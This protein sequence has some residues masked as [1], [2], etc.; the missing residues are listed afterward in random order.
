VRSDA[1]RALVELKSSDDF[2]SV[3]LRVASKQKPFRWD[4]WEF[5]YDLLVHP[6]KIHQLNESNLLKL[7]FLI[8]QLK[9]HETIT[10]QTAVDS[11]AVQ[12]IL[13][14]ARRL[15][16]VQSV[17]FN[18]QVDGDY[19]FR[20]DT[21]PNRDPDSYSETLRQYH[22]LL[23]S[24]SLPDGS[25]LKLS[26]Q[27]SGT[28]LY[29]SSPKGEFNLTSD[30]ISH[31]YHYVKRMQHILDAL[32]PAWSRFIYD[33]LHRIGGYSLFPGNKKDGSMTINQARGCNQRIVDRFDLTL[34]CIRRFYEGN[35]SPLTKTF[36]VY[37]DFFELFSS[38]EGFVDFFALQDLVDSKYSTVKF[39]LP[40][41]ETFPLK[42]FPKD[43]DEYDVFIRNTLGF[44]LSRTKRL[45][46]YSQEF[47]ESKP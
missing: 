5:G 16:D 39:F 4:T 14:S 6:K 34:E 1:L 32:D 38:F 45:T 47:L 29:Y 36:G 11:G 17:K 37:S 44:V 33:D 40:F 27:R 28:Y 31:S 19:D 22:K 18:A 23:W 46:N 21:P 43:L 41:D 8:T 12:E 13:D 10:F 3:F 7:V 26:D 15:T 9:N 35:D 30:S 2:L 24:K 42:P 20:A 25:I